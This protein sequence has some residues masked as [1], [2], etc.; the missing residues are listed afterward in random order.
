MIV[1]RALVMEAINR[2]FVTCKTDE[3]V[4]GEQATQSNGGFLRCYARMKPMIPCCGVRSSCFIA[5]MM[6]VCMIF[7]LKLSSISGLRKH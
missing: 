4:Y 1:K 6:K 7:V 5:L 2:V 3:K